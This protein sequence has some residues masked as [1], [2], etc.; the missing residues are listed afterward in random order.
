MG[1]EQFL[2]DLLAVPLQQSLDAARKCNDAPVNGIVAAA[3]GMIALFPDENT[4][5]LP[6]LLAQRKPE[7][8]FLVRRMES[9][10]DRAAIIMDATAFR[11]IV[12]GC[13]LAYAQCAWLTSAYDGTED[14]PYR[15]R[16]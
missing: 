16:Q 2:K 14:E 4:G 7:L 10:P 9:S 8:E 12:M 13:A 5:Y 11:K 6:H 15:R 1:D 3:K